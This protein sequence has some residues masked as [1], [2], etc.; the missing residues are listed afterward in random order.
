M[1]TCLRCN[2]S[3]L[4]HGTLMGFSMIGFRPTNRDGKPAGNLVLNGAACLDCG[5]V[6]FSLDPKRVKEEI[7]KE[8]ST[9]K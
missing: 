9:E 2:G 5:A 1:N 7:A 8:E 3:N 4:N 6:S